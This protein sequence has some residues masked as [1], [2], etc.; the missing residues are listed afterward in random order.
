MKKG[1]FLKILN[2]ILAADFA[3]I[4]VTASL[5]DIIIPSGFYEGVHVIPGFL[6]IALVVTHLVL[7]RKWI[8]T[9]Y[10]MRK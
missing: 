9:H 3:V 10:F 6:L 5:H 1:G 2:I 8:K 7:N 4:A